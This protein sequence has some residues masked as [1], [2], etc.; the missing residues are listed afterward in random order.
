MDWEWG[1]SLTL[2]WTNF[3]KMRISHRFFQVLLLSVW[4][5][6]VIAIFKIVPDK[7]QAGHLTGTGFIVLP[8]ILLGNE[9][10]NPLRSKFVLFSYLQFLVFFAVPIVTMRLMSPTTP[11]EQIE[12]LGIPAEV[13]HKGSNLSYLIMI[14]SV[15]G[16]WYFEKKSSR[17]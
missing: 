12:F 2:F 15:V 16:A 10:L 9:A 14:I 3:L 4:I 6:V 8:L 1:L 7:I 13:W 5:P 11:F 17:N